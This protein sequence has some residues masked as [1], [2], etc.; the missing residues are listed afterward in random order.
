MKLQEEKKNVEKKFRNHCLRKHGTGKTA[1]SK[2][3]SINCTFY[4]AM[5]YVM[6]NVPFQCI[7]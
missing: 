7:T 6:S 4:I 2:I 5:Q 1:T 3:T